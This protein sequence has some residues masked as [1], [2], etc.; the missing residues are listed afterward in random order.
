LQLNVSG[1]GSYV[2]SSLT[3]G[4]NVS[5]I[6]ACSLVDGETCPQSCSLATAVVLSP[7]YTAV[8]WQWVF[9]SISDYYGFQGLELNP[10]SFEYEANNARLSTATFD[11]VCSLS[12]EILS[13]KIPFRIRR[14]EMKN[15]RFILIC[16]SVYTYAGYIHI[17]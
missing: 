16:V 4:E 5:S 7:V 14:K 2:T 13:Q 11:V 10:R 3:R 8:T 17:L 6:I 12:E 1:H 15:T 9:M